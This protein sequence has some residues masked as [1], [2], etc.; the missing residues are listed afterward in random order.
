[1]DANGENP[2]IFIDKELIRGHPSL[3]QRWD[4]R[5]PA[6]AT[7][8]STTRHLNG[9]IAGCPASGALEST[10]TSLPFAQN[11]PPQAHNWVSKAYEGIRRCVRYIPG[12]ICQ[13]YAR[14]V[15]GTPSPT[16]FL[17][18]SC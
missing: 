2:A 8:Q 1:M 5:K 13:R 17:C 12:P 11:Y 10:M 18:F 9:C 6:P 4:C 3:L 7:Y 16:F 14:S 15:P